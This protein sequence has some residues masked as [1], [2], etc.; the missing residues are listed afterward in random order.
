MNVINKFLS[1]FE[2][3]IVKSSTYSKLE[4]FKSLADEYSFILKY[5]SKIA[6]KYLK[7]K[8]LSKSQLGQDLFVLCESF[9]KKDGFF[10]EFGAT[11]GVFLS[12][13]YLLEKQFGWRGILV[14]P[15]RVWH[16]D[17]TDNRNVVI[18]KNCV[19][20]KSGEEIMFKETNDATLSTI[21]GYG[22]S[23][24]HSKKRDTTK[25]YFVQTISLTDLLKKHKAPST[26][27]YLSI[28]TEGSEFDILSNF[29][30]TKY[31]IKILSVEHNY[32]EQRNKLY[33]LLTQKGFVRVLE[34]YSLFDDWYI[35]EE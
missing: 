16:K 2:Y 26:I 17:L 29:D 19:W 30:F 31:K 33:V 32:T 13:T 5:D 25:E 11:D 10:I 9:F 21:A 23:D 8:G 27:D 22:Q 12:N 14:E 18:D 20:S 35:L 34:E 6:S 1:N 28:D 4:S 15:A 3:R 7:Y 24:N